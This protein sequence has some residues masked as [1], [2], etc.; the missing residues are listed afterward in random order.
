VTFDVDRAAERRFLAAYTPREIERILDRAAEAGAEAGASTLRDAAPVGT[1]PV[2]R[3]QAPH[4]SFRASVRAARVR[5][6]RDG[7]AAGQVIGP[8]GFH[9]FMRGWIAKRDRWAERAM[10]RS[11][12][13]A[14]TASD[15]LLAQYAEA[16]R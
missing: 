12:A 5:R 3:R 14:R 1:G 15:R 10:G 2:G 6:P 16:R 4:G 7:A 9:S 13:A 11:F 8:M